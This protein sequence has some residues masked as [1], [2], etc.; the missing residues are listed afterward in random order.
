[1]IIQKMHITTTYSKSAISILRQ[2]ASTT[3]EKTLQ[4]NS[5]EIIGDIINEEKVALLQNGIGNYISYKMGNAYLQYEYPAEGAR[6]DGTLPAGGQGTRSG[7][8]QVNLTSEALLDLGESITR[9]VCEDVVPN[10][11][12]EGTNWD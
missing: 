10:T 3:D 8:G 12:A 11:P 5:D 9:I 1:M 2:L 6:A 4:L 7:Q